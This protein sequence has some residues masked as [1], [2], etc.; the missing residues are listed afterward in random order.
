VDS[1][2]RSATLAPLSQ[3][4]GRVVPALRLDDD[5]QSGLAGGLVLDDH[6][7]VGQE[8]HRHHLAQIGRTERDRD[9]GGQVNVG[10]GP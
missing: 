9:L 5:D 10:H 4:L 2:F 6:D 8:L 7:R 3:R 1:R